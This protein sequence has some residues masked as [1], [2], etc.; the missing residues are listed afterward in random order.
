MKKVGQKTGF[1]R[2]FFHFFQFHKSTAKL[3]TFMD[4]SGDHLKNTGAKKGSKKGSKMA[5]N[6]C[7]LVV[8]WM[9]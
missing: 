5:K 9:S 1:F 2:H 8:S 7:F 3:E 4:S 6:R